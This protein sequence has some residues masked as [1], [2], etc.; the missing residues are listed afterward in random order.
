MAAGDDGQLTEA[1]AASLRSAAAS[2]AVEVKD[3]K[4][5]SETTSAL[6]TGVGEPAPP[7]STPASSTHPADAAD[8]T[9]GPKEPTSQQQDGHAKHAPTKTSGGVDG[10]PSGS[11]TDHDAKQPQAQPQPQPQHQRP[12]RP[13]IVARAIE[14]MRARRGEMVDAERILPAL[15]SQFGKEV[16]K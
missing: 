4:Q 2:R 6:A 10:A 1:V 3:E 9:T 7:S 5:S 12:P 8:A 14:V 11:I 15:E 13:P 16:C